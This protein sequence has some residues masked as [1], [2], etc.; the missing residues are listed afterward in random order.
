MA[1]HRRRSTLCALALCLVGT[2]A[3]AAAL[4][5]QPSLTTLAIEPAPASAPKKDAGLGPQIDALLSDPAF[6]DAQIGISVY[7][8]QTK[9]KL[10]SRGDDLPLGL[11]RSLH[12][13]PQGHC[14]KE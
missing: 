9:K 11:A 7:D 13:C 5:L 12:S 4:P 8:L 2:D 6:A 1:P 14:G 10:Y 3:G